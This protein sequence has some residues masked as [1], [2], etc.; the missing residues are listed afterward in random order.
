MS[1]IYDSTSRYRPHLRW[2]DE[3]ENHPFA[4]I[5]KHGQRISLNASLPF[6]SKLNIRV[7]ANRFHH[8][9]NENNRVKASATIQRLDPRYEHEHREAVRKAYLQHYSTL[10]PDDYR[11]INSSIQYEKFPIHHQISLPISL[12]IDRR[13]FLYIHNGEIFARC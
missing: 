11:R 8:D 6:Y 7:H 5:K 12:P 10:S 4:T 13:L 3:S 9:S 1:Q 2:N